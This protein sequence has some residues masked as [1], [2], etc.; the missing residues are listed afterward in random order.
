MIQAYIIVADL[1]KNV[2]IVMI[3]ARKINA[4]V[5]NAFQKRMLIVV[6]TV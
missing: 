5:A 2:A 4:V 3:V 1:V 6:A